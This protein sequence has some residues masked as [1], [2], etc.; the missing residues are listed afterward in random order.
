MANF[1]IAAVQTDLNNFLKSCID[2]I[3]KSETR[4][5]INYLGIKLPLQTEIDRQMIKEVVVQL[6]SNSIKFSH[7]GTPI[8]VKLKEN[9][10]DIKIR[11]SDKGVGIPEAEKE[12]IFDSFRR[13]SNI[14]NVRGTGIGL[15][16]SKKFILLHG[17]NIT[18]KS[19]L[20]EGTTFIVTLP[21]SQK[22][23]DGK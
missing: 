18:V 21:K 6:L 12:Y 8:Q 23:R 9:K 1:G 19:Q 11:F 15:A 10:N 22:R 7:P 16:L 2:D 14:F 17:G 13:C 4:H 3:K 5:K 20:N